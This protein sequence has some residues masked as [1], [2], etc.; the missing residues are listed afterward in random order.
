MSGRYELDR[1]WSDAYVEEINRV[2]RKVAGK[3]ITIQQSDSVRDRR[4]GVDYEV[5]VSSGDIAC[6]VRRAD[7]FTFRDFTITTTRPSG[8][9]PE[10]DKLG[11]RQGPRWYLYAWAADGRFLEWIFV[12]VPKLVESGLL[13]SAVDQNQLKKN[14]DGSEFLFVPVTDLVAAGVLV[15]SDLRPQGR[16]LR[17]VS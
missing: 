3:I 7:R 11:S 5:T 10:I 14:S 12:D 1:S 16:R 2:V 9:T 17:E 4:D 6:R 15:A 8:V 13:N